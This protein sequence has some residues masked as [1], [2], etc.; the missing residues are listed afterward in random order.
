[1]AGLIVTTIFDNFCESNDALTC[2]LICDVT[3]ALFVN[4]DRFRR[5][6]VIMNLLT[7]ANF[8]CSTVKVERRAVLQ[9]QQRHLSACPGAL[10]TYA[11]TGCC[12]LIW[13]DLMTRIQSVFSLWRFVMD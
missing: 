1:M 11:Q 10:C 4:C 13:S 7:N 3:G 8:P 6:Q 12:A 9:R 5:E 2:E